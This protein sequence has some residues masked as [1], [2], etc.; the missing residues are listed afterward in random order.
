M[1]YKNK[2]YDNNDPNVP[3]AG[4]ASQGPVGTGVSIE[5]RNDTVMDNVI[6]DNGAWG[7][8][9]QPYPDTETPP[10]NVVK[11]G[12]ACRAGSP[13]FSL[14]GVNIAC[15]Y[16][17]WGGRTIGNTFTNDGFFGNPTNGDMAQATFTPDHAI[18]C[19]AGNRDTDGT[20]TSSPASMQTTN[21]DC[22]QIAT[23]PTTNY[24][25]VFEIICDSE[26]FGPG[27]GCSATDHYARETKVVMHKLPSHLTSM[28]NACAGVPKNPWCT[29]PKKT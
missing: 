8:S 27:F 3:A 17:D 19:Y 4:A 9:Y 2:I 5:G 25:F 28:K 12:K 10:A 24:S 29:A 13:N 16:D 6:K 21:T 15:L 22:G 18:N 20:L 11:A 7:V 26:A 1:L 23:T 14:L